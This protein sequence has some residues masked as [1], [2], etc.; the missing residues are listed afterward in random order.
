MMLADSYALVEEGAKPE[1]FVTP[2]PQ[3]GHQWILWGVTSHDCMIQ[4]VIG[5][6]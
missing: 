5:Q 4:A 6:C 2:P 3:G 1:S